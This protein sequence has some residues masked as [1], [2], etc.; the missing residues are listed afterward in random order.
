MPPLTEIPTTPPVGYKNLERRL[1]GGE[2]QFAAKETA[3]N[4]PLPTN[5]AWLAMTRKVHPQARRHRGEIPELAA[6]AAAVGGLYRCRSSVMLQEI[7][8][9]G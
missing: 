9:V 6:P 3:V 7:S 1:A 8:R 5:F 2:Q 4:I